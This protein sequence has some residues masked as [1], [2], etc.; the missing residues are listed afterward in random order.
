ME[1]KRFLFSLLALMTI[2]VTSVSAKSAA[3]ISATVKDS[4]TKQPIEFAT[5][6][7]LSAHDSLLIGC[8][9]DSKGYFE[10]TPPAKTGKIRIRYLGY[11]NLEMVFKDRDLGTLLMEEDSKQLNEV[12]VKGSARQNKID[13]D[14]FTITK[15]LK[16][17]T[18]SSQ[19]LLGKLNGVNYNRYDKSISVNGSTKVL[20]LID[21]VEK[22]QQMA[23]TLSPDRIER[24]EVIKDPVGKY[25]TDGYT[26]VINIVLKKDYSGVDFYVGNTTF[27][28]LAGSNGSQW[29]VQDYGNMNLTYTYKKYNIYMSGWGY[30][31]NFCL[32]F[33]NIKKYGSITTASDPFDF[34]NPNGRIK[35]ASGSASL[36]G[37]YMLSKTQ[38]I[39][40]EINWSGDKQNQSF[41]NNLTNSN[42]GVFLSRSTS[43]S[44]Q[45]GHNNS[46]TTT[47]TY[48]GKFG[49]K[50]TLTSDLRYGFG[51]G[52]SDN[53]YEQDNFLSASNIDKS[54]NYI[55]F[56]AGYTYQFNPLL[57]MELGYGLKSQSNTNK[58]SGT[59]FSYDEL[60]NRFSL[61]VSYQPLK[62]WKM[63]GG[64]VL[65]TYH[66]NYLGESRN[67]SAFLPYFNLQFTASPKFNVVAKY[68]TFA[69]YPSMDQLTPFKTASDSLTWNVGNPDLKTAIYQKLGLE[70]HIMNFITI[71]PYYHF[72]NKRIASFVSNVGKYYYISNVN[73]DLYQRYGVQLNFTLPLS[74]TIF[75]QNWMDFYKN[76]LEFNGVGTTV[77]NSLI[78]STLVYVNPKIGL[79]AGAVLQK[80]LCKDAAIQGY[81]S[82]NNDL[83]V[84]FINKSLMKQ[85]LN[86]TLMYM[87]PVEMGLKY[88]QTNVT[89]AGSYYQMS[90]ASLNLIKNLTFVEV[91]YHFNAGKEVKKRESVP[92]GDAAKKKSGGI[93]L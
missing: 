37:D 72:D 18:A 6:E 78:N 64:G 10:I 76:H 69:D 3:D 50:S 46:I 7:L 29:F 90:R 51:S 85:K 1:S 52:V 19:E 11:K 57:S 20:I 75:W 93:G 9:T 13:R 31:N 55:R 49:E 22:D 14:V 40:A 30:G 41:L 39:S 27:F 65:E 87:P 8:I 79:T 24:V 23:K 43:E 53:T 56:N 73:A 45:K 61:Y 83:I 48:N 28:D 33:D 77:R 91:N 47:I 63:K 26:A 86:I 89:E 54:S 12:A 88:E 80:Q 5:V 21:G 34:D 16:A 84:L 44:L 67:V 82:N 60:K 36:G 70:F 15:E 17:G 32:P 68:H 74:K 38:T 92:D 81:T 4:Q 59:S 62:K 25:A 71:E 58:L 42:N 35:D 66:Q 2:C